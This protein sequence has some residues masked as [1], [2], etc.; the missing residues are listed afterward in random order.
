MY[1]F[2]AQAASNIHTIFITFFSYFNK[3]NFGRL[4]FPV[5]SKIHKKILVEP[6]KYSNFQFLPKKNCIDFLTAL[7]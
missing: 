4:N 2:V 1:I 5:E 6:G 7:D 3:T